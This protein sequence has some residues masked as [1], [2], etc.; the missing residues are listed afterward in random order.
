MKSVRHENSIVINNMNLLL[1]GILAVLISFSCAFNIQRSAAIHRTNRSFGTSRNIPQRVRSCYV[2]L[3]AAPT[4][5]LPSQQESEELGI[6]DWPQQT[7]SSSWTDEAEEGQ[8]LVR[9]ILQGSGTLDVDGGR[10]SKNFKTGMLVEVKGPVKLDWKKDEG[11]DVIILTPG[12][13]KGGL[14]AGALIGFVAMVGA[15]IALS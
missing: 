10:S 5:T 12:F 11:E 1:L 14:F 6:R 8:T 4:Y 15:L 7:K 3:A 2:G 9:Y 13:E